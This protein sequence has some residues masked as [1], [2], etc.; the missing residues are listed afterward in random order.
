MYSQ[1]QE[2]YQQPGLPSFSSLP[3]LRLTL[4][5]DR[6]YRTDCSVASSENECNQTQRVSGELYTLQDGGGRGNKTDNCECARGRRGLLCYIFKKQRS[7]KDACSSPN[8]TGSLKSGTKLF[9]IL[10]VLLHQGNVILEF[11][12]KIR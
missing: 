4:M 2:V 5:N 1:S 11:T 8:W 7:F 9:Q 6:D 10:R 3:L 12:T